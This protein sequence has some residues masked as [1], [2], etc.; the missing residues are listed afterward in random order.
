[1]YLQRVVGVSQ[2]ESNESIRI[3]DQTRRQRIETV[4]NL[5]GEKVD[6]SRQSCQRKSTRIAKGLLSLFC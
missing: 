5:R 2:N 1:M 3:A 4:K 6:L